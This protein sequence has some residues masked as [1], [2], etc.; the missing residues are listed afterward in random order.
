MIVI[1][2]MMH[3]YASAM[4]AVPTGVVG[5]WGWWSSKRMRGEADGDTPGPGE[6]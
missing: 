3:W 4:F 2:C 1:A 6:A 5:V